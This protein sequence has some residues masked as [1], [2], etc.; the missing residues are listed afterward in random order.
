MARVVRFHQ[1]GGPEVLSIEEVAVPAPGPGEVRIRVKALGLNRAEAMLRT[2]NYIETATFPS[3]L[4]FEAAGIVDAV[5][6]G[7]AD[8]KAG[9]AV[10]VVPPL[11]QLRWPAYGELATFPAAHVVKHPAALGFEAAAA[12]W[13]QYVTAYGAL[14]DI[15]K[16]QPKDFVVVTAASSS[17]GLAAIQIARMVGA[18]PIAVTRTSEKK[19]ALLEAGAA[20][21]IASAEED[22]RARL[23]AIA[24]T[25][26]VRVVFDPIG[27]PAFVPLTAAMAR[28][29][30]LIEYG[31]LSP[32]PTPFP[33]FAVLGKSL[34]LRGYLV[35]EITG[36]PIRLQAAKTF[37]LGGLE[38]GVLKPII[39]KVFPFE[40]IV[41][42]HR[43]LESNQQ[44]GKIVVT[45]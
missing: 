35:H 22:L 12:V 21:V 4:G 33:L 27:G 42:A 11:S 39:A 14:I 8:L 43:Y 6:E 24:G 36:D 2:G 19:P 40:E 17:V 23:E 15:A 37:V 3:G 1:L 18:T 45:I 20:H 26:G 38:S 41:A 30:I 28:G 25:N 29:G 9:D 7:V 5:G 32:E 44:F 31:A 13:M 16:L 10:S 34:T